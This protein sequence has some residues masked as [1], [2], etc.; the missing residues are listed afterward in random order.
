MQISLIFS[1]YKMLLSVEASLQNFD[2]RDSDW[3]SSS[4]A[5]THGPH[6]RAMSDLRASLTRRA[7]GCKTLVQH[8]SLE[9]KPANLGYLGIMAVKLAVVVIVVQDTSNKPTRLIKFICTDNR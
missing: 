4:L 6:N 2:H 8:S 5:S 9:V 3:M 1:V 7:F